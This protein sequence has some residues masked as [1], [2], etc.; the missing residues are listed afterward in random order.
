MKEIITEDY[1]Y[2]QIRGMN[3]DD[4]EDELYSIFSF[5]DVSID[6]IKIFY[7]AEVEDYYIYSVNV[8]GE[9][10]DDDMQFYI[11]VNNINEVVDLM[12]YL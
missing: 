3:L 12:H 2:K 1:I 4:V 8:F 5:A 6:A 9:D 11:E 7:Y 10:E